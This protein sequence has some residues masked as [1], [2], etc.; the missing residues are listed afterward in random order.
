MTD[1]VIQYNIEAKRSKEDRRNSIL[2]FLF[3][4]LFYFFISWCDV[5]LFVT[6]KKLIFKNNN[7]WYVENLLKTCWKIVGKLLG[8]LKLVENYVEMLKTIFIFVY[9]CML[10]TC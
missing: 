7:F 5:E 1:K 2:F 6:Q 3:F 8:C 10:K 4:S 9:I